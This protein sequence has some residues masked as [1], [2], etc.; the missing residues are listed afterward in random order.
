M[1]SAFPSAQSSAQPAPLHPPHEQAQPSQPP[2]SSH[3]SSVS[4]MATT[5]QSATDSGKSAPMDLSDEPLED[6]LAAEQQQ[7]RQ[8]EP[9]G[10]LF[11]QLRSPGPTRPS[12]QSSSSSSVLGRRTAPPTVTVDLAPQKKAR[13]SRHDEKLVSVA[14]CG[15]CHSLEPSCRRPLAERG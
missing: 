3:P 5:Q 9:A 11:S 1:L 2:Q 15:C 14:G 4:P 10:S 7:Q 12:R 8:R 6:L 13:T